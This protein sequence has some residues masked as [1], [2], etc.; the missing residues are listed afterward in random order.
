M[1]EKQRVVQKFLLSGVNLSECIYRTITVQA[2]NGL[3]K[4]KSFVFGRR[5]ER[6]K[7]VSTNYLVLEIG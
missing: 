7:K 2:G 3:S 5:V 1:G 6:V 4:H